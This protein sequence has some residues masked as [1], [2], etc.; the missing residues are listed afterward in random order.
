MVNNN[1]KTKIRFPYEVPAVDGIDM[2]LAVI[3]EVGE[4]QCLKGK[5]Y[6]V[7]SRSFNLEQIMN[8]GKPHGYEQTCLLILK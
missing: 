4:V 5:R 7:D 8:G 1:I 2:R 3:P 6:V